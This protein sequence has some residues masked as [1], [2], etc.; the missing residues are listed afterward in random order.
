MFA[1]GGVKFKNECA[2]HAVPGSST[3][4]SPAYRASTEL[5]TPFNGFL[6]Q[7]L[8]GARVGVIALPQ[9]FEPSSGR[10]RDVAHLV[11]GR[12]D[13]DSSLQRLSAHVEEVDTAC[14]H[15]DEALTAYPAAA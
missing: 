12:V 5:P 10:G 3:F 13:S 6:R 2:T 9:E 4:G 11:H 14:T 1:L 8:R 15:R 7:I